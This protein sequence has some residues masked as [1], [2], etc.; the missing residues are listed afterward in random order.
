MK[1]SAAALTVIGVDV[2][3]IASWQRATQLSHKVHYAPSRTGVP[4]CTYR[5]FKSSSER[6]SPG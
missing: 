5:L 6:V 4:R 1:G 2:G 3:E